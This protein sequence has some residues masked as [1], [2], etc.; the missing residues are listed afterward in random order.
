MATIHP[1]QYRLDSEPLSK[2]V[3]KRSPPIWRGDRKILQSRRHNFY[4]K[5]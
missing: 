2:T 4:L 3:S 1:P 5:V